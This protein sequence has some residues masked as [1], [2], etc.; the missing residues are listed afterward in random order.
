M[1]HV[2]LL[3]GDGSVRVRPHRVPGARL[4][5]EGRQGLQGLHLVVADL[6]AVARRGPVDLLLLRRLF[7]WKFGTSEAAVDVEPVPGPVHFD[8]IVSTTQCNLHYCIIRMIPIQGWA[9]TWSPGSEN[10]SGKLLL[11]S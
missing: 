2:R 4:E 5:V 10:I 1:L 8:W 6:V 9:K 7:C 3:D 11:F